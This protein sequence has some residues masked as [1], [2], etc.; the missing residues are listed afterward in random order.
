M[1]STINEVNE[2]DENAIIGDIE[3]PSLTTGECSWV[4]FTNCTIGSGC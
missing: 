3:T 4:T 2:L 1:N